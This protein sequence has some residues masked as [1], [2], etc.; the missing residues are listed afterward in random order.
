MRTKAPQKAHISLHPHLLL[1]LASCRERST[2]R[3]TSLIP[4]VK[5]EQKNVN[6]L[7]LSPAKLLPAPPQLSISGFRLQD[8]Q[9]APYCVLEILLSRILANPE[10]RG[11]SVECYA[12]SFSQCPAPWECGSCQVQL[13][14]RTIISFTNATLVYIDLNR[15]HHEFPL[16]TLVWF[17]P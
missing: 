10:G 1:G 8:D 15:G 3:R 2:A 4:G 11:V 16:S 14:M 9:K 12:I 6:R 17:F 5:L 7:G 13:G